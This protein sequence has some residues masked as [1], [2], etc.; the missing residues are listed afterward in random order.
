MKVN[1]KIYF[2]IILVLVENFLIFF[3]LSRVF[4]MDK[5]NI[6]LENA[7]NM[8]L[9]IIGLS[10]I[11]SYTLG[12][13]L[14]LIKLNNESIK[15]LS[16]SQEIIDA[17]RAQKHDF[18][19]HL[20]VI[21]GLLHMNEINKAKEYIYDINGRIEEAFSI[22]KLNNVEF[23]AI[24]HTKVAI[25]E[26][27]G[28]EV[29][30]DIEC[31]LDNMYINNIDLCRIFFNLMDNACYELEKCK[32]EKPIL[33]IEIKE[34]EDNVILCVTNSYPIISKEIMNKIFNKGFSSKSGTGRG[35]G[36]Y[37]VKELV[38]KH[39]GKITVE[40]YE[41]VGTIFTVFLPINVKAN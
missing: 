6:S 39:S 14:N 29:E 13:I 3:T 8:I 21:L 35:Y 19:N 37:I 32:V 22:S 18:K 33:T 27:K 34:F 5:K 16:S 20:S 30:L 40:S 24:L 15:K 23:A 2:L 25:A 1:K 38:K 10:I 7:K 31:G 41:G 12:G 17:L 36:L 11:A 9:I 28:I 26:A 4:L